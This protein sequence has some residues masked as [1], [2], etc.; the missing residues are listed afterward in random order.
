MAAESSNESKVERFSWPPGSDSLGVWRHLKAISWSFNSIK[1]RGEKRG[2]KVFLIF[3]Y[4]CKSLYVSI[5]V[6]CF[7]ILYLTQ[8]WLHNS[9]ARWQFSSALTFN[10][11]AS[12]LLETKSSVTEIGCVCGTWVPGSPL[13]WGK[14]ETRRQAFRLDSAG[15]NQFLAGYVSWQL[16]WQAL[17]LW[18]RR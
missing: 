9:N 7:I 14:T 8:T 2:K 13:R 11:L 18:E 4:F 1:K 6:K 10:C 15:V 3:V 16:F 5:L 17:S 12:N